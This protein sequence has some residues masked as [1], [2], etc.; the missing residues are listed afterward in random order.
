MLFYLLSAKSSGYVLIVFTL[1]EVWES[2][3]SW[4]TKLA[5]EIGQSRELYVKVKVNVDLYSALSWTHL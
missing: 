1:L 2:V 5:T 4:L 3:A